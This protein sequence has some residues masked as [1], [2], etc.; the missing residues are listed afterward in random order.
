[1]TGTARRLMALLLLAL[2]AW[3]AAPGARAEVLELRQ[4][5]VNVMQPDEPPGWRD[6]ML[7][8][9]WDRVHRNVPGHASFEIPFDF[10][11]APSE[12]Y[13]LF[14]PVVGNAA[15][16]WLNDKLL[17]RFGDVATPNRDDY[18][19]APR[20]VA[21]PPAML[22]KEN[23]L[24]V[25]IRA[26]GGRR[27]GLSTIRLGPSHEMR[28]NVF[29]HAYAWRVTGS[30][31][32]GMFSLLVAFIAFTCWATQRQ[33][34]PDGR[35]HR[36][37]VY[38]WAGVAELC[39]TLRVGDAVIQ[40]PPLAWPLWG[41]VLTA[42]YAG[43][44][45]GVLLFCHHVAGWRAH[46][47]MRWMQVATAA[48][49]ASGVLASWLS[50]AQHQPVFLTAW[51]GFASLS[52][53]LYA[54]FYF[55]AT[56]RHPTTA[57]WLVAGAGML[58][59]AVG[60]RD[61][62]MIRLSDSFGVITWN[63]YVSVVFGLALLYIVLLRFREASGQARELLGTLAARVAQREQELAST[64]GRLEQAAREQARTHE[65]ERILR[66]MHDGVGS[67]ISAAIRQLQAGEGSQP[68]LLRT[69]RDSLDQL[70]LTID[71]IH[72][73]DGD[74]GALLAALRYRLAPRFDASGIALE[75]AVDELV[76][77]ERLDAQAMRHLQFLLFEA[78]SNV[79]QHAQATVLRIEAAMVG[80]AV[81]LSVIDDGRGYDASRAP[82]SLRERAQ[83]MGVRLVLE[84]RPGRTVV[85]LE[86]A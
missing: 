82:R 11:E 7:P 39:W 10:A 70:K 72:L 77:V 26:D 17:A 80:T 2:A 58:N 59:V 8:Y 66:D 73:P 1:M 52:S 41:V 29:S 15:E 31:L 56:L 46:R 3:A 14:F 38:F 45:C 67:H 86:M 36:D 9:H 23:L 81:R 75:W 5:R 62:V 44:I 76:P 65:R 74:V 85:Q 64:Y 35:L 48:L 6:T 47:S 18:A 53:A 20:Y 71:S 27:G 69:L 4:A 63:R 25:H 50:F 54:C 30:L 33:L 16:I 60:V 40:E 49:F 42:S 28:D 61:W 57:R 34:A 32:L 13:G 83:A 55:V 51:L 37:S 68:E 24:R 79:L 78:I 22:Q 19:K 43:W 21:V 12:P 84:S